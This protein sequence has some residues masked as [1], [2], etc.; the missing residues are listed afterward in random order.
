M[1]LHLSTDCC[2]LQTTDGND[3][4]L[5][6]RH[7]SGVRISPCQVIS[8]GELPDALWALTHAK[9]LVNLAEDP[10]RPQPRGADDG[11]GHW[12]MRPEVSSA[13]GRPTLGGPKPVG[14]GGIPTGDIAPK[15]CP[16]GIGAP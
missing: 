7:S 9:A 3:R 13:E 16:T 4:L 8:S 12:V 14:D 11:A 6:N 2:D 10:H 15:I 1:Q 5:I